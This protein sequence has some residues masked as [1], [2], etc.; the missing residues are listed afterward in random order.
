[1]S[2][3]PPS[4]SV[5]VPCRNYGRY[6][7]ESLDS[8]LAQTLRPCQIIV[9]NDGSTDETAAVAARYAPKVVYLETHG[10]GVCA[11]RNIG[12]SRV[13]GEY[14]IFLDAD[15]LLDPTYIEKT[16]ARI[17]ASKD[18]MEAFVYTQR[19]VFGATTSVSRYPKFCASYLKGRNFIMVN[20]L[21][22]A[23][24]ARL[25]GYDPAFNRGLEDYD[26]FLSLAAKG[27]RGLLVDEVLVSIRVH[28]ESTSACINCNYRQLA[29][30]R[31]ILRKHGAFFNAEE[32]AAAYLTARYSLMNAIVQ[33]RT[34]DRPRLGRLVDVCQILRTP[35][36]VGEVLR[37]VRFAFGGIAPPK[38]CDY[39]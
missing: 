36:G 24:V 8:A 6:L 20:A 33:N 19:K 11:A 27:Y 2:G 35:A 22:R 4:V 37:Q 29:L 30:L 9:V 13:T 26:F 10:A 7:P 14:V 32:R 3:G 21:I 16:T 39:P 34:A 31:Q 28:Q 12:L 23:D 5:V 25:V 1:M 17:V 18:P 15:D 38:P